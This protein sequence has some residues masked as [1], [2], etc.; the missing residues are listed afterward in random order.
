MSIHNKL[1]F[2]G[3]VGAG[4]TTAIRAISTS[5][6]IETEAP[7]SDGPIGEKTTTTVAMDYSYLELDG[8]I[9]H[10]YGL[11]GQ[12]RLGFMRDILADGALGA[13]LLLDASSEHLYGDTEHWLQSLA[14]F[15]PDLLLVIGITKTDCSPEFSLNRLR[16][17]VNRCAGATPMLSI[18]AREATDVKQLL[19]VMLV[20]RAPNQ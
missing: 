17:V 15:G 6:P 3:P 13:I 7:L 11:P 2:A 19:R 1:L 9:I 20:S 12:K 5:G 16:Q 4:K 10:L 18:D 14:S 8:E